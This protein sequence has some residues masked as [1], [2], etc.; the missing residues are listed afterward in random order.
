MKHF[1]KRLLPFIAGFALSIGLD[2]TAGAADWQKKAD[3]L[4][5]QPLSVSWTNNGA[6]SQINLVEIRD[7]FLAFNA[8]GQPGEASMPLNTLGEIWFT[9]SSSPEYNKAIGII[10]KDNFNLQHLELLRQTAYPMVRFLDIPQKNCAFV[11]VV[12]NLVT[13]LINLGQLDE[14]TSLIGQLDISQLGP[15]FEKKAIQLAQALVDE[16]AHAKAVEVIKQVPVDKIDLSNTDIIFVLAH[17]LREQENFTDARNIYQQLS[18]N[19]AIESKESEYWSYYCGLNLGELIEDHTFDKKAAVIEPGD[20]HFPLQQLVLGIYYAKREQGKEAMRAISQ[21]IAFATPVEP[22]TPELM[23]RSALAYEKVKMTDISKSV[24]EET[25]R[26]F[27]NSKWA[28][29]A[30]Q[31]LDK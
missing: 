18:Q 31:E 27:P 11:A 26:F 20:A 21:G 8:T 3:R 23:Y 19:K 6:V 10:E 5:S 1:N 28:A 16:D 12:S 9:H 15:E 17:T 13:G 4:S 30:Q 2:S 25:V 29:S 24:F 14:A 22:W 7:G